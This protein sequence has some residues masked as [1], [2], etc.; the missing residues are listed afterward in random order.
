M[1]IAIYTCITDNYDP[2]YPP[3][4]VDSRLDYF[5]FTEDPSIVV[6]PW[7][8]K[9]IEFPSLNA[10]DQNRYIKMHP[11]RVLPEY[12]MTLYIDGSI[13]I[14]GDVYEMITSTISLGGDVFLYD[15]FERN[16]VYREA[17]VC[18]KYAHDWIWII[19]RQMRR[20]CNDGYPVSNGLYEANVM[21]RKNINSVSKVMEYWWVEYS[22]GVRRDQISLPYV[23]WKLG[24]TI[25]TMGRSDPRFRQKYFRFFDHV[26][27]RKLL[28]LIRA[29]I[30]RSVAAIIPYNRLF[31]RGCAANK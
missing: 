7:E 22:Q 24:F 8:F 29:C 12:D 14:V 30:N 2:L 21:L 6:A 23:C 28:L 11:H 31:L 19:A 5:C 16:C 17:A 26:R 18:A 10:K 4:H 9:R 3:A 15:H 20:Y 25:T 1:K 27:Q 13:Q